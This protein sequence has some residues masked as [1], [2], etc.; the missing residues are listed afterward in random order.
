MRLK[1]SEKPLVLSEFGGY[2]YREAGHV[3]NLQKSYGYRTFQDR[4]AYMDALE[5]LYLR[6]VVPAREQGLCGCIYTQLSDVED[7]INGLYSYDRA[8]CKV[9]RERMRKI[10][11]KLKF[12]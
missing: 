9:D 2:T 5:A 6:E 7:E 12:R 10:G 3:F 1:K 11:E 4:G 8:V